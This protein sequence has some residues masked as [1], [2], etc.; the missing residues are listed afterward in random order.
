MPMWNREQ[1]KKQME[2]LWAMKLKNPASIL[3]GCLA[4]LHR[5]QQ[6]EML[7]DDGINSREY[8]ALRDAI[9]ECDLILM[10]FERI[11]A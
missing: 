4:F 2:H 7:C 3:H 9:Y 11:E 5:A 10:E 8:Y 1:D 6:I